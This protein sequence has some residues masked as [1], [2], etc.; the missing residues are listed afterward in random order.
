MKKKPPTTEAIRRGFSILGLMQPNYLITTKEIHG[1]LVDEGFN[2]SLRT[3]ERDMKQLPDIFPN[4]IFVND[5]SKPYGYKLPREH[6]KYSGMSPSEAVCL[7]LAFDYLLLPIILHLGNFC[8]IIEPTPPIKPPPPTAIK[9]AS[10]P[11]LC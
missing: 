11:V 1:K 10:I 5:R 3:V 6:R 7:Q 9:T 8:R 2:I 4:Q